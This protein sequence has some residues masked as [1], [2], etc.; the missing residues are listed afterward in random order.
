MPKFSIGWIRYHIACLYG[1]LD[2]IVNNKKPSTDFEDGFKVQKI[3]DAVM[4]SSKS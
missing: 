3:M 2:A 4:Q 1:F